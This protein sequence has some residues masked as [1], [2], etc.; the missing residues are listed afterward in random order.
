MSEARHTARLVLQGHIIDS[1]LLP[2]VMD[3]VMDLGGNFNI[4]ELK[5]GQHKTDPSYCR[6]EV[7]ASSAELLERIVRGTRALGATAESEQPAQVQEVAQDGVFPEGFYSTSNL[8][9]EVLI[10]GR[11]LAVENME[12][13]AAIAVDRAAG[14]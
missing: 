9:T 4:E 8:P 11:W 13:D 5:V 3:L 10:D 6:L 7:A 2:Q 14:R 1:F 12:M